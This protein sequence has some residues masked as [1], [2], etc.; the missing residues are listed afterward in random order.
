MDVRELKPGFAVE[1]TGVDLAAPLDRPTFRAIDAALV[2]YG[3]TVFPGQKLDNES[4]AEFARQFGELEESAKV[5]RSDNKHRT[6]PRAIIDVSNLDENDRPRGR[7][8]RGG[9]PR[10]AGACALPR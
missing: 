4:Q 6:A 2:K 5:Y 9:R 1:I 3:V 7:D 8:D 10:P